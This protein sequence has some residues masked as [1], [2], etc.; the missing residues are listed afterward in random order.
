LQIAFYGLNLNTSSILPAIGFGDPKTTNTSRAV[1]NSLYNICVG[2][3]IISA[4]GLIPGYYA[5]L[6]VIDSWGRKRIQF[7]GFTMLTILLAI[8]GL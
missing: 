1:Y 2:N 5:S 8:M 4:A 7:M 6:A 3:M